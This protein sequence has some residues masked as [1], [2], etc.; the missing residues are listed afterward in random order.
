MSSAFA[1]ETSPAPAEA[2]TVAGAPP[3]P[4]A[5]PADAIATAPVETPPLTPANVPTTLQPTAGDFPPLPPSRPCARPDTDGMWKLAAVY[6]NPRS[7]MSTDFAN[8]PHQYILF[9]RDDTYRT[10]KEVWGDKSDAEVRTDL[11]QEQPPALQQFLVHQSGILFFYKDGVFLDSQACFIVAN[12]KG[13]YNEGQMILMPP[14]G[15][16]SIRLAMVY[17]RIIKSAEVRA[18]DIIPNNQPRRRVRRR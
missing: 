17:H 15:Q 9:L 14:E 4:S 1:Q 6:E 8:Y 5:A 2:A 7:A 13:P 3:P 11:E 18:N 16:S 10:Y 12:S